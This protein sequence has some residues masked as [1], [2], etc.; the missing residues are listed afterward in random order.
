MSVLTK[1][2]FIFKSLKAENNLI[3]MQKNER[4]I[5][6]YIYIYIYIC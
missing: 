6:I 2:I 5:Y 4:M 1:N 3:T